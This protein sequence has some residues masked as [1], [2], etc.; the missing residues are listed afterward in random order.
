M[1]ER[2]GVLLVAVAACSWGTWSIFLRYADVDPLVAT[3]IVFLLMGLF[4][5]P[6]ALRSREPAQWN[7]GTRRLLLA[8]A[9]FAGGN[10]L[11]YFGAI[12]N[13]SVALAIMTHYLAPVLIAL[14]AP[15]FEGARVPG[16]R[17]A[18]VVSSIGLVLVLEP[19]NA[20]APGQDHVLGVVL[21]CASAVFF[22]GTVLSA[23]RLVPRIGAGRTMAYQAL[24]AG[25]ILL[26]LSLPEAWN[27]TP[28]AF[29]LLAL[30]ALIPGAAAGV[31]FLRGLAV[32][33]SSRAAILTYL[34][35]LVALA[36]GWA[37]FHE[38]LGVL[39]AVGAAIILGAGYATSGARAPAHNTY[40]HRRQNHTGPAKME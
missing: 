25:L 31:F 7:P 28:R 5:L 18:A 36:I 35:P 20:R 12:A 32:I 17:A 24:I 4:A 40:I 33:G 2:Q 27:V 30:G 37:V 6:V 26:P 11:T 19:W 8:N 9:L 13:T 38:G 3:P 15:R 34:E 1:G 16:A 10:V 29:G 21:G 23:K 22:A 39:A 14:I